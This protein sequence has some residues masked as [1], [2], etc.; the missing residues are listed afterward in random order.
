MSREAK[1]EKKVKANQNKW[2]KN[3]F[4]QSLTTIIRVTSRG[5]FWYKTSL[6]TM[7][8][9]FPE[10]GDY[11][12]MNPSICFFK[13]D[14][15]NTEYRVW[16]PFC[17]KLA[18]AILSVVEKIHIE[19]GTKVLYLS[20][21]SGTTVSHVSDLVGPVRSFAL[22][23]IECKIP[24]WTLCITLAHYPV[25]WKPIF[26]QNIIHYIYDSSNMTPRGPKSK[27]LEYFIRILEKVVCKFCAFSLTA[28]F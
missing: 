17:S 11:E 12:S 23:M 4:F 1:P 3:I 8:K 9:P 27:L 7:T 10:T 13:R 2:M 14:E 20:A 26:P 24:F 28:F 6:V 15:T 5:C 16:N 21:G 22:Y 25:I 18:G 19:P